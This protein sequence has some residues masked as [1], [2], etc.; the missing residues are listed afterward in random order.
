MLESFLVVAVG[1]R[2]T[3]HSPPKRLP[4]A[5][6]QLQQPL[7]L[8]LQAFPLASQHRAIFLLPTRLHMPQMPFLRGLAAL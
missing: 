2:R 3:A 6:L 5:L 8:C 4:Y 7:M 1:L